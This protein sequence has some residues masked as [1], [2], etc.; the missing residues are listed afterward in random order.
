MA[1]MNVPA[2]HVSES[3]ASERQRAH[4]L[5]LVVMIANGKSSVML[6]QRHIHIVPIHSASTQ[7][8]VC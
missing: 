3:A 1:G 7:V 4:L 5:H 6:G 8:N 2:I